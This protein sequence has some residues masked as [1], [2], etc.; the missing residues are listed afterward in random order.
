MITL[1]SASP[2]RSELL[3]NLTNNFTVEPSNVDEGSTHKNP[4]K[5]TLDIAR[6]KAMWS[7]GD[8]I[9]SADTTVYYKGE[10]F[11]KPKDIESAVKMLLTLSGKWHN[12]YTGVCIKTVE[13][14][15]QFVEVSKVKFKDLSESAVREYVEKYKPLDKAGAYGIQDNEIV[16][17]YKGSYS[18][19]MGLPLEKLEKLLR[20]IEKEQNIKLL[21]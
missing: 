15:Y 14:T 2:R 13:K 5:M 21:V 17:K 16:E 18:N 3:K 9:L 20:K 4:K 12:V 7:G 8:V 10:H 11:G 1:A 6:S 19:I